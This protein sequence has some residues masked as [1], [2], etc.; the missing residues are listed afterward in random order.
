MTHRRASSRPCSPCWPP[1]RRHATAHGHIARA[2]QQT[3]T[4]ARR[5]RQV[6]EIA[7]LV[8]AGDRRRAAGLALEHIVEFPDDAELL[9]RVAPSSTPAPSRPPA[10]A[11]TVGRARGPPVAGGREEQRR[12]RHLA[13]RR[14]GNRRDDVSHILTKLA[15]RDRM[16]AV[17]L[18]D[19]SRLVTPG[20]TT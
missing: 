10:T 11:L 8:V 3:R 2:Q 6:V 17:V 20:A 9:G 16:Q 15:L 5:E 13:L 14:R 12:D 1:R 18:A 4:T 19:E 7:A